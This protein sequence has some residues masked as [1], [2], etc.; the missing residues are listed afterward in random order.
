MRVLLVSPIGNNQNGGIGKWTDHIMSFYKDHA[1]GLE[2]KLY[3]NLKAK[4]NFETNS[5]IHRLYNGVCN[6]LP[7]VSG[8]RKMI[9][10]ER[11][12]VLHICTS[13][14]ISLVKD[15][16]IVK[17]AKKRRV[18]SFVHCHFGRIPEVLKSKGLEKKLFDKLINIV[19]G[20]VVMD[21]SSF[22]ALHEYGCH[23]VYYLPNPL[24]ASVEQFI[25][26][27]KEILRVPNKIVFVGHVMKTKG[28]FELVEACRQLAGMNL[29]ILGHIPDE[30]VKHRLLVMAGEDCDSWLHIT[31]ALP[32]ENVIK[33]MLSC[34]VFVLPT[35][36]EGFPNVIIESMACGCP[37]VTTPV[38]AIPEM[39]DINGRTPCGICVEPK[40]VEELK[41]AI[42]FFLENEEEAKS[43]G[44]RAK[45]RVREQYSINRVWNQ[46]VSIWNGAEA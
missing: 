14:S 29:V 4:A 42:Q 11:F 38:G 21:L 12:D 20:I 46:L 28:V 35:Y 33:E 37:I 9:K 8:C 25:K 45:N 5:F 26:G 17:A 40:N 34:S 36:T 3:H 27:N 24:A 7:I 10:K 22:N 39:L 13:A 15:I 23:N 6:Y 44:E 31:G 19:D 18:K 32:F 1:D 41:K 16:L 43:Y 30:T 2:L